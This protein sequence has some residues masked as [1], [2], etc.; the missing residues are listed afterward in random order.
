MNKKYQFK[1]SSTNHDVVPAGWQYICKMAKALG[2]LIII[3]MITGNQLSRV[4]CCKEAHRKCVPAL[5]QKC[6][7]SE[8]SLDKQWFF[9]YCCSI[10]NLVWLTH[11]SPDNPET[12]ATHDDCSEA[13]NTGLFTQLKSSTFR[14]SVRF[15]LGSWDE[16]E[17]F[18]DI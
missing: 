18:N 16:Q 13:L 8:Q 4:P 2:T 15:C 11:H 14:H 5:D 7:N 3:I 17:Y 1:Y 6:T 10:Y 9:S 12:A